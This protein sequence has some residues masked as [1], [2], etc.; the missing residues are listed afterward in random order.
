MVVEK[1]KQHNKTKTSFK[2]MGERHYLKEKKVVRHGGS[3]L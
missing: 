3:H 1:K 2:L